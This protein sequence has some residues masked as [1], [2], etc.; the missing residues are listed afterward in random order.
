MRRVD[1]AQ[2]YELLARCDEARLLAECG[3]WEDAKV[4]ARSLG[5]RWPGEP[6]VLGLLGNLAHR[7]GAISEAMRHWD[8]LYDALGF[9]PTTHSSYER[10]RMLAAANDCAPSAE[11]WVSA[12]RT[13]DFLAQ[14]GKLSAY[15]RLARSRRRL[16]NEEGAREA[17]A[18]YEEAFRRRMHWLSPT[19]RMQALRGRP[20]P[21]QR[22]RGLGLP[23]LDALP[24]G[25]SR[26]IALLAKERARAARRAVGADE[27]WRSVALL[28][29]GEGAEA[30]KILSA[31][32]VEGGVPDGPT[33]F[34]LAHALAL[35]PH[36]QALRPALEL[37]RA[38]LERICARAAPDEEALFY[39]G[40]LLAR[41]GDEGEARAVFGRLRAARRR[42]W[43]PAGV[44]RAAAICSLRGRQRGLVHDVIVRRHPPRRAEGGRLL[45]TEIHGEFAPGARAQLRRTFASVREWLLGLYPERRAAIDASAYGIHVTKEDQPSGG[46][47]IGLPVAM[48][49]AS[50]ML[51][52]P[53]S[54]RIV[55]SGALS[56]DALA[57]I[58]VLPVGDAGLKV[59][60]ALHAGASL[61]VLPR[62]QEEE[63]LSGEQVPRRIAMRST[64]FVESLDEALRLLP[65]PPPA[66]AV[67]ALGAIEDK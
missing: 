41:M 23:A 22:L 30:A 9:P 60:G 63:V 2:S 33:G 35:A 29:G 40:L 17:E 39:L 42:R 24:D 45:E 67:R 43:P 7:E 56:Y 62:A 59:K 16:G 1:S 3:F 5:A 50:S 44:V 15:E 34:L 58:A 26:G 61:L 64:A 21:V 51:G 32:L 10:L 57:R 66:S 6:E 46:P 36:A 31:R 49:F 20:L 13:W 52:I 14:S 38:S 48:A 18:A 11:G 47:S 37:A 54:S 53:V 12:A 4:L 28:A 65:S 25:L 8:A 55:F 19:E 27:G